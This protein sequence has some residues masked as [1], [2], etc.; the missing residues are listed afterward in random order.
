M[1][2][3]AFDG[4]LFAMYV[5]HLPKSLHRSTESPFTPSDASIILRDI[6][7][8]LAYLVTQQVLH[9]DIKPANIAYSPER[10][11][12]LLDFGLAESSASPRPTGGTPWY[13]PP[14]SLSQKVRGAPGDVW[15]L[16]VTMLYVLGEIQLPERTGKGWIIKDLRDETAESHRRMK[17]WIDFVE[18]GRGK[19]GSYRAGGGSRVQD[20][21]TT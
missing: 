1:S 2:L 17:R 6:S 16:G 12:V 13:M 11:A 5:E 20:A 10:G 19:A 9:N 18:Q 4:R 3:K 21:A 7:S 14:E 8:A 15:A